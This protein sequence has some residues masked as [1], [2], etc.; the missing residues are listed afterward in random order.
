[1]IGNIKLVIAGGIVTF[2]LV[3]TAAMIPMLNQKKMTKIPVKYHI[4]IGR[5]AVVFA[6]MHGL[7]AAVT[8]LGF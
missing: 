8:F 2:I 1:M 3:L 6:F 4:L 5:V 7:Y